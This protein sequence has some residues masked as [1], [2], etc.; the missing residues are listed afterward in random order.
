MNP[1]PFGEIWRRYE[2]P[3]PVAQAHMIAPDP[4]SAIMGPW[5]SGK[6]TENF[7]KG[8]LL[9]TCVPPSPVDGVRYAKGVVVR[10]T[11]RNLANTTI[12]TFKANFSR[13]MGHLDGRRER[14]RRKRD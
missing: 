3:G 11:Y 2:P 9:S 4:I 8:L 1:V 6:T 12:Q 10:E 5:G 14:A 7:M 13:R